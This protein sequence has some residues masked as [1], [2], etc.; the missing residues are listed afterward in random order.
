LAV[1]IVLAMMLPLVA[2][3]DF[4]CMAGKLQ[5]GSRRSELTA[6]SPTSKSPAPFCE[7]KQSAAVGALSA[8]S[9]VPPMQAAALVVSD[10]PCYAVSTHT[11]FANPL[12]FL[13]YR[14]TAASAPAL[15]I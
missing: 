4:S 6:S 1:L 8:P 3:Q 2:G 7:L 10:A 15:R 9:S 11:E 13:R 12:K 14:V 5:H